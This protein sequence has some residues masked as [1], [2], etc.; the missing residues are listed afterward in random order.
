MRF[1]LDQDVYAVT[2]RHLER[3]GHDV[4]TAGS[5]GLSGATDAALLAKAKAQGRVLVTRGC[6]FGGLTFLGEIKSGVLY[7]RMTPWTADAVHAELEQVLHRYSEEQLLSAFVVV[8]PG[9]HRF[10]R[11]M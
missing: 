9:R 1:L 2:A 6:D 4:Q 8:E 5:L 7:L 3:L 11:L 10:R